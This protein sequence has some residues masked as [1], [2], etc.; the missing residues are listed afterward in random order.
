A[1]DRAGGVLAAREED[2]AVAADGDVVDVGAGN[3]G[4]VDLRAASVGAEAN[5]DHVC[6]GELAHEDGAAAAGRVADL[7]AVDGGLGT[8]LDV[9]GDDRVGNRDGAVGGRAGVADEV[10]DGGAGADDLDALRVGAIAVELHRDAGRRG[11]RAVEVAEPAH[12]QGV[13]RVLRGGAGQIGTEAVGEA[14][15]VAPGDGPVERGAAR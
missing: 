15:V 12:G 5:V 4:D 1:V 13:D 9:E 10:D 7:E 6:K 11:Q 3:V 2:R 8:V 14:G